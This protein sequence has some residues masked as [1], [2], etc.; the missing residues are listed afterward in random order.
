MSQIDAEDAE[1]RRKRIA[2]LE[3]QITECESELSLL[4]SGQEDEMEQ[5]DPQ[6]GDIPEGALELAGCL[7][8]SLKGRAR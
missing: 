7:R 5:V 4:R 6:D 1:Q 8:E 3:A 2:E